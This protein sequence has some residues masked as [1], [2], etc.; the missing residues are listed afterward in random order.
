MQLQAGPVTADYADGFLRYIRIGDREMIRMIYF[1]I[2]DQD[3]N[4]L[5]M[6]IKQ[7][8]V[9]IDDEGFTVDLMSDVQIQSVKF[10]WK[11]RIAGSADGTIDFTIKGKALSP[12]LK[13]RIGFCILHPTDS[14]A[15]KPCSIEHPGGYF[16]HDFFPE[17]IAP[18]QPFIN[19]KA[20]QWLV[21]G[22]ITARLDFEGDIFETEDQRNWS[23]A[24]FKTY[25]T[26]LNLPF[27]VMMQ[28]GDTVTQS[29]RFQANLGNNTAHDFPKK[30]LEIHILEERRPFPAIGLQFPA[31]LGMLA[32]Y[33]TKFLSKT[34]FAHFRWD[35]FLSFSDWSEKLDRAFS[36]SQRLKTPLELVVFL[37]GP[38]D[39]A[40]NSLVSILKAN[41]GKV[42][43]VMLVEAKSKTT[44]ALLAENVT[45]LMQKELP[46]IS[47]GAGTDSN[48]AEINRN[49]VLFD[50][51]SFISYSLNPQVHLPDNLTLIENLA[52][53]FDQVKGAEN[54]AG[55]P[56][57]ISPVTLKPRFNAV[58]TSGENEAEHYDERQDTEFAATWTLGSLKY[59]SEAGA[60]SITYFETTGRGG[61]MQGTAIFPVGLLLGFIL[62]WK[63]QEVQ[64]THCNAHLK[65][66]SLL[67]HKSEASCLLVANHTD[68]EQVMR[69][70]DEIVPVQITSVVSEFGDLENT[71]DNGF[72]KIAPNQIL[73]LLY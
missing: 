19:I 46:E 57:H 51:Q 66:S 40:L 52:A 26:P 72:L 42:K 24:S 58:A 65:I 16:C 59:L 14:L 43:S 62:K 38:E 17:D 22:S 5:P 30:Q 6:I 36:Q 23:D 68:S 2:R 35:V 33:H 49:P 27:P 69:L 50:N 39:P 3:W 20:M 37:D 60:K 55:K 9:R 44:S 21:N 56:V 25:S 34:G 48:F 71:L 64:L 70:P 67:L 53:Q 54:L 12:F 45:A 61:I 29:V 41:A 1:A 13:N 31:D 8:T 47:F 28:K 32:A 18:H 73:A 10:N 11:I 7:E 15:G 63:P 4:T